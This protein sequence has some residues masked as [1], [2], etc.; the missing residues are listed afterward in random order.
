M[1]ASSVGAYSP[2][3][4]T[5]PGVS[6]HWPTHGWAGAA[7]T[8]EKAYLERALDTFECDYPDTTVVRMRP[9][10]VFKRSAADEQR[11][12]F[13]GPFVPRWLLRRALIPSAPGIPGLTFQAVHSLDVG[14]AFAEAAL[15]NVH[16]AF[17]LAADPVLTP[18]VLAGIVGAR[19]VRIPRPIARAVVA[20]LWRLRLVPASPGLFDAV[21][22][23]PVID[24]A[25]A[26]DELDWIPKFSATDAVEEF[27]E[28]NRSA[29]RI[30][31]PPLA[32]KDVR[33]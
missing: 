29:P 26:R 13:G 28:G 3:P 8:R 15:R 25:R 6:E 9:A 20:T 10:F 33:L 21:L 11:R 24:S 2:G 30:D 23:I 19:L 4:K 31:T 12:L 7:Y 16:G 5:L 14:R 18:D 1:T 32:G 27:F 22:R 17:N